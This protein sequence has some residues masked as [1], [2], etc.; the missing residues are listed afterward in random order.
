MRILGFDWDETNR[1]K[2]GLHDLEADDIEKLF[3][4]GDPYIFKH[5]SDRRRHIALGFVPD[6]RFVLVVFEHNQTTRWVRVVTAY[7]PTSPG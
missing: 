7:E 5:T 2:L 3:D 4:V 1:G 6:E